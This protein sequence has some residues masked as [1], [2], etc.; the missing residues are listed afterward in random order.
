MVL[1]FWIVLGILAF[2]PVAIGLGLA[3]LYLYL[4]WKYLGFLVRIFQEKPLFVVPK[5]Q[6]TDAAE[7]VGFPAADG[8]TL[9]GCYLR[10]T[11]DGPRKGVVLFGLEFG[12]DRW[13][14][15]GYCD[16]LLAAGYDVFSFEPRNQGDSDRD[17]AYEPLQWV[18][19]KDAADMRAALAY[20]RGRPDADPAG[21]GVFGVS[22]GGSTAFLVAA[23]EPGVKCLVTDGAYATYTT[24][25]PYMKRWIGIYS[26]RHRLQQALPGWFYGLVG[27]VGVKK[28]ARN[29][30]VNY[31]S[32]E[33][34]VGRLRRPVLMIHGEADAYIKPEMGRALFDRVKGPKDWWL[35]PKAKHNQS[36]HA[37]GDE[38]HARVV[39]FFDRHLAG[40]VGASAAVLAVG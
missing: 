12:S 1:W 27:V 4:R 6:P 26:Q 3:A 17:P 28:V 25:V 13:A 29:R 39:A 31:P 5:G 2:P 37:A 33:K 8:L 20:L 21:V 22:K 24:M 30:G 11:A 36:L 38:Y 14:C 7:P 10:T 40:V 15:L 32:V 16:G 35:V 18:T 34:A 23:A 9:R 19:D